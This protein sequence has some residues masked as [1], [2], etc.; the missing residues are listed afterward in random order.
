MSH[1]FISINHVI[2]FLM[3][4]NKIRSDLIYVNHCQQNFQNSALGKMLEE[5][6]SPVTLPVAWM[7]QLINQ[8]T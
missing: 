6:V 3:A 4:S 2:F 7:L 8:L 1:N 5:H